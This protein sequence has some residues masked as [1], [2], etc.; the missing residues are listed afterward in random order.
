MQNLIL[1]LKLSNE[2]TLLGYCDSKQ[3]RNYLYGMDVFVFPSKQEG[4]PVALM[5]AL[6]TGIAVRAS[7]VRGNRELIENKEKMSK[8]DMHVVR[9]KM[10]EIYAEVISY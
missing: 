9:K 4:L 5:E 6:A 3:V 2:V 10:E 8:Y 1:E 7:N